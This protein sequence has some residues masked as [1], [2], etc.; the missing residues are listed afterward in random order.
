[1]NTFFIRL[2]ELLEHLNGC[3]TDAPAWLGRNL[4]G[5]VWGLWWALLFG[6][7]TL[8]CGQSSKFIYIDF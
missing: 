3:S 2:K 5:W 1:M 8:F 7:I 6:V 4:P